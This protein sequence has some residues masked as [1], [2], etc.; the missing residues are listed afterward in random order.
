[1]AQRKARKAK[2]RAKKASA[3]RATP[4]RKKAARKAMRR[5]AASA[6]PGG[7]SKRIAELEEENRRLREELATL[8]AERIE[9]EPP[10]E[11]EPDD[12]TPAY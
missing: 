3:K 8:R 11:P 7:D 6:R 1:M 12:S 10:A 9:A 5:P 2:G 4:R